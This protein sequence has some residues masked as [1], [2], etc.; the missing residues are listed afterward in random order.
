M[1]DEG[2]LS[3]QLLLLIRFIGLQCLRSAMTEDT[4]VVTLR[5]ESG[6]CRPASYQV[7]SRARQKHP[8]PGKRRMAVLYA[9]VVFRMLHYIAE[10]A[11]I[12][13]KAG[14]I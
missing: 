8:D 13:D 14:G 5:G 11:P 6:T 4:A 1:T 12:A 3:F 7:G 2:A 10:C 9:I